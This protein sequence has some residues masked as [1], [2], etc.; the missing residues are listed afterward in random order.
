MEAVTL[1]PDPTPPG[2]QIGPAEALAVFTPCAAYALTD[3]ED[4]A[5]FDSLVKAVADFGQDI[6][7]Q[8]LM[9]DFIHA[10][11][12]LGRLRR[13]V[14]RAYRAGR[15]FAVAKLEGRDHCFGESSFPTGR[16]K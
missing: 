2:L 11:W 15:P 13:M 8:M 16:Y 4:D 3:S 10:E 9:A 14:P 7:E 6:I 1:Q 5:E 12:E